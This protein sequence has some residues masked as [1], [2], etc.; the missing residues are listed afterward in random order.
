M[1]PF[2]GVHSSQIRN[3]INKLLCSAYL[4]IQICCIFRPM[5]RLSAFFRFKDRIPLSLRSHIFINTSVNAVMHCMLV[6]PFAI[7]ISVFLNTWVFRPL[8][9]NLSQSLLSL[10]FVIIIRLLVILSLLMISPFSTF[11]RKIRHSKKKEIERKKSYNKKYKSSD[12]GQRKL[13]N[14]LKIL[15]RYIEN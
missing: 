15:Q 11:E 14:H 4:H 12:Q 13:K 8:Q 9:V 5:Q 2:L 3:Q 6:K 7:F 10:I 1:L